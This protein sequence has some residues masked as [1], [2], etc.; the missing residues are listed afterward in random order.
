[1]IISHPQNAVFKELSLDSSESIDNLLPSIRLSSV[2]E[3]VILKD[4]LDILD[5]LK[6]VKSLAGNA[7][8]LAFE[9]KGKNYLIFSYSEQ[10]VYRMPE[11]DESFV[12][13]N[14]YIQSDKGDR[15]VALDMQKLLD[16]FKSDNEIENIKK[17]F[18]LFKSQIKQAKEV[19]L[20]NVENKLLTLLSFHLLLDRCDKISVQI[21]DEV[22]L[23]KESNV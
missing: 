9:Y 1:M 13:N 16:Q 5:L 22:I 3:F 4:N 23:L 15:R 21:G 17:A 18:E 14:E 20:K 8:E 10:E 11:V 12:E 7:Q 6:I 2:G 19:I